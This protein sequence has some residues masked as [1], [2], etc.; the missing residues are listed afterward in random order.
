MGTNEG[1]VQRE[2]SLS[3]SP[4]AG[5]GMPKYILIVDDHAQLRKLVRAYL[6]REGGFLVCGEAVD[7]FDALEKAQILK[8]DLIVLDLSMPKM[9]GIEV[10]PRLKKMLPRT[11]IIMLTS[12]H[13]AL[14][15]HDAISLGIDAVI[16]KGGDMT[17]LANSVQNLL[18]GA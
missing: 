10:A 1:E 12:Y 18:Q 9:S 16:A 5:E 15:N 14:R 17:L 4:G 3:P 8:P 13:T 2:R 6:E 11:P 7:G